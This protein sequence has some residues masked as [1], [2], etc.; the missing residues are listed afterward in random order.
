MQ[1]IPGAGLVNECA[2][3][4]ACL[5]P[6]SIRYAANRP[7]KTRELRLL[8]GAEAGDIVVR[9]AERVLP[10]ERALEKEDA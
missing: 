3:P 9:R 5:D 2:C 6:E 4:T 8:P 1:P 7:P 10:S